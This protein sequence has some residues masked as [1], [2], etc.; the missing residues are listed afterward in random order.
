[1]QRCIRV[2]IT[3]LRKLAAAHENRVIRPRFS[4]LAERA[5]AVYLSVAI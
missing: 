1:L 2:S 5:E 3:Q 4:A